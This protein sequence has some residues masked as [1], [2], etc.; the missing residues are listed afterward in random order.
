[1]KIK[2]NLSI[3]LI[4]TSDFNSLGFLRTLSRLVKNL[5]VVKGRL[6][7]PL[8]LSEKVNNLLGAHPGP[9]PKNNTF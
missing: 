7:R 4:K 2:C 8:T 3:V 5:E 1:M 9:N 6:N